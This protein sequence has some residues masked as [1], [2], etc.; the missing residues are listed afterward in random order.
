MVVRLANTFDS[1]M[2]CEWDWILRAKKKWARILRDYKGG[3]KLPKT[4]VSI[5]RKNT[6]RGWM[7]RGLPDPGKAPDK[8]LD[9]PDFAFRDWHGGKKADGSEL[10]NETFL[11]WD[12]SYIW[13]YKNLE[14]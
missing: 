5:V 10:D 8:L 13:I 3:E 1:G 4:A 9:G 14:T 11:L 7:G 12:P 2:K 6:G